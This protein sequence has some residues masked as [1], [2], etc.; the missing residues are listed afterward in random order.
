MSAWYVREI[1]T[2]GMLDVILMIKPEGGC[3]Q[4]VPR[5]EPRLDRSPSGSSRLD[6]GSHPLC[7]IDGNEFVH[8]FSDML[9]RW[10]AIIFEFPDR[11]RF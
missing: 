10:A 2:R 1:L 5:G 8:A 3:V 7:N 6:S 11:R 4:L 9:F